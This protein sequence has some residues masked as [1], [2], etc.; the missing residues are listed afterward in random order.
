[1]YHRTCVWRSFPAENKTNKI[2]YLSLPTIWLECFP[3]L[4]LL[5]AELISTPAT[6]QWYQSILYDHLKQVDSKNLSSWGNK[7]FISFPLFTPT[8]WTYRWKWKENSGFYHKETFSTTICAVLLYY[9][10]Q[11]IPMWPTCNGCNKLLF[12]NKMLLPLVKNE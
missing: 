10:L 8:F 4:Y 7:C 6:I 9:T 12:Y 1:M 5:A 2:C 3:K 11:A